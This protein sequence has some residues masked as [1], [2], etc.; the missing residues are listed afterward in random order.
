MG[1]VTSA[2][3]VVLSG[4]WQAFEA[5]SAWIVITVLGLIAALVAL[6]AAWH[7]AYRYRARRRPTHLVMGAMPGEVGDD[8]LAMLQKRQ[9]PREVRPRHGCDDDTFVINGLTTEINDFFREYGR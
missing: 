9:A 2:S 7:A 4:A 8:T 3:A 5:A 6:G 1:T